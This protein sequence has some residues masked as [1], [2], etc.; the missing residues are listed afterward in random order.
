MLWTITIILFIL[1]VGSAFAVMDK[2]GILKAVISRLVHAFGREADAHEL[3]RRPAAM[4]PQ[5]AAFTGA[6]KIM[7]ARPRLPRTRPGFQLAHLHH[8]RFLI[9][10]ADAPVETVGAEIQQPAAV[11]EVIL[12]RVQH[13]LGIVFV[14][15]A[16]QHDAV[17]LQRGDA[18]AV[19]ILI[20]DD[21]VIVFHCFQP[22]DDRAERNRATGAERGL[23]QQSIADGSRDR[24][25]HCDT[26][27]SRGQPADG[28]SGQ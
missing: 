16:V 18:I 25:L 28:N 12:R 21:V 7:L 27:G 6:G 15:R 24:C 23:V 14:V 22:A 13:L 4:P 17:G 2:S 9:P 11:R 1:L 20:G 5:A 3:L 10:E 26:D 19:Q 8:P